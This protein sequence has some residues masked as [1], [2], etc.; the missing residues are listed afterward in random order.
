MTNKC[1][2]LE[3]GTPWGI[4]TKRGARTGGGEKD[5]HFE[6]LRLDDLGAGASSGG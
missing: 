2:R 5:R 6:R 3:T 4:E 1:K